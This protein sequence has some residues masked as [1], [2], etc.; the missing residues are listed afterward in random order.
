MEKG[1]NLLAKIICTGFAVGVFLIAFNNG[2]WITG[3][4]EGTAMALAN[5]DA[6]NGSVDIS[7]GSQG[8]IDNVASN[9]N[10]IGKVGA[11][12]FFVSGL[13]IAVLPLWFN[14]ND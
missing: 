10:I 12:L 14:P 9:G 3:T 13:L 2:L 4:M 5:L 6:M 7:A 1:A 8:L 11:Y